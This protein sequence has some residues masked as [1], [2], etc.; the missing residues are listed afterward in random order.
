MSDRGDPKSG[1]KPKVEKLEL[2][3]ETVQNLTESEAEAAQ[4]GMSVIK[5]RSKDCT[6]RCRNTIMCTK[7]IPC[8]TYAY[9]CKRCG[10]V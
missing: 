7:A 9:T 4:G 5:L 1:R 6:G 10:P 8:N 3:K 2:N